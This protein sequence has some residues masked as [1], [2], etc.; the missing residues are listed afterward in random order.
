MRAEF[1]EEIYKSNLE[2]REIV[3]NDTVDDS[4]IELITMQILK[5]NKEDDKKE[6]KEVGYKREDHP[7]KIYINS[8]G[9]YVYDCF[10][11]VSAIENSKTP[12]YTY[13]L[14]KAMSCGFLVLIAGHK[15][16]AQK[17]SYLLYHQVSSKANGKFKD[18]VEEVEHVKDLQS[19]FEGI[20]LDKT[21]ITQQKLN[22]IKDKKID[23]FIK[24]KEALKLKVIDEII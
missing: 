20:V 18:L 5:F 23:W 11:V 19:V 14:G 1:K 4:I 12:V 21:N 22:E 16:F 2:N 9:G 8:Y 17:Y 15:R 24:P 7:I 3:F 10:S 13:A 6:E